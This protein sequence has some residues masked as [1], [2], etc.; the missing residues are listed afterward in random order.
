MDRE[1]KDTIASQA[2]RL[3]AY[4]HQ[5]NIMEKELGRLRIQ[6]DYARKPKWSMEDI[7]V[8]RLKNENMSL[9]TENSESR[10]K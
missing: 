8:N 9:K 10:G 3:V 6:N 2:Q 1:Y 4:E 5:L 7:E